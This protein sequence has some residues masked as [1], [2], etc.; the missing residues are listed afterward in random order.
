MVTTYL[1]AIITRELATM[2]AELL[3]FEN[4]SDIWKTPAGI[5]N[6]TGTLALH[7]AGNLRHFIGAKLGDTG[8]VR[9]R[10]AEFADREVPRARILERLEAAAEEVATTMDAMDP[11]RLEERVDLGF[12][13]GKRPVVLDFLLHLSAHL[14]FHVGQAGY[15]RRLVTGDGRSAGGVGIPHL[16]SLRAGG[17]G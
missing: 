10:D 15:H 17:A 4:E 9:D 16:A 8:Y 3:A 6:P 14:A 13:D 7:V 1:S 12:G 11:A 2:R 5:A